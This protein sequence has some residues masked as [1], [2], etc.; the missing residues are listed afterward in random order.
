MELLLDAG[1][2][3]CIAYP[4]ELCKM[5]MVI[6]GGSENGTFSTSG[7]RH[8]HA[9]AVHVVPFMILCICTDRLQ[10]FANIDDRRIRCL[11]VVKVG[12]SADVGIRICY[13]S[14]T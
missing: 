5:M 6:G 2:D 9:S 10:A 1:K 8:V 12:M 14:C 7:S 13:V 3:R 11:R 4:G